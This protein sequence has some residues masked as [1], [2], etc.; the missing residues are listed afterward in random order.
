MLL[1]LPGVTPDPTLGQGGGAIYAA[2]FHI[3]NITTSTFTNNAALRLNVTD[4]KTGRGAGG[5]I[6][7]NSDAPI[8]SSCSA[9]TVA[10]T[11]TN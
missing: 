4:F 1:A 11:G 2:T 5:A 3:L 7:V 9:G 8:T 6:S 10:I